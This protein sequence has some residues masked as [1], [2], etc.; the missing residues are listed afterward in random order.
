MARR[1]L[2]NGR[3]AAAFAA[4]D[5]AVAIPRGETTYTVDLDEATVRLLTQGICPE[6]LATRMHRLLA[7]ER[8]QYRVD[9]MNRKERNTP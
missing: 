8:E 3:Y 7:W 2:G 6:E 4:R 1:R 9:A 5:E